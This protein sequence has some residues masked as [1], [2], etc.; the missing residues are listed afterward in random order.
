M[1]KSEVNYQIHPYDSEFKF[2]TRFK[3]STF[4]IF[5]NQ[6]PIKLNWNLILPSDFSSSFRDLSSEQDSKL[7]F[8]FLCPFPSRPA[9]HRIPHLYFTLCS[10]NEISC[11]FPSSF[12]VAISLQ[13]HEYSFCWCRTLVDLHPVQPRARQW[14][15]TTC[16]LGVDHGC[17]RDQNLP[18]SRWQFLSTT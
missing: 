15:I 9:P 3:N 16:H 7:K 11:I 6:L 5:G 18:S 2:Q 12:F 10:C 4:I 17:V 13:N 14:V 1:I 8:H